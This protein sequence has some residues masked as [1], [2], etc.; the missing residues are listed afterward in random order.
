MDAVDLRDIDFDTV[1]ACSDA[2][3]L[4]RMIDLLVAEPYYPDLLAAARDR[5]R[6][7]S[8]VDAKRLDAA[9][10]P[11]PLSPTTPEIRSQINEWVD[12]IGKVDR[13][14][15][16]TEGGAAP[17]VR[18]GVRGAA[19]RRSTPAPVDDAMPGGSRQIQEFN[20]ER[21]KQI[22]NEYFRSGEYST[23]VKH[24]T[25]AI[26]LAPPGSKAAAVAYCN[27]AN[28][29]MRLK[30]WKAA[31]KDASAAIDCDPSY[32]KA[33]F[34]R[35]KARARL[36]KAVDARDDLAHAVRLDPDN[37]AI[38]DQLANV[39]KK[40]DG[41]RTDER[42]TRLSIVEED[43][44]G[45]DAAEGAPAPV[46]ETGDRDD[47]MDNARDLKR[48]GVAAFAKGDHERAVR[49]YTECITVCEGK[50][51]ER[52]DAA[53]LMAT[54]LSNRGLALANQGDTQG[55]E[56]DYS[57]ALV[58]TNGPC[59]LRS[60]LL[61]R[62]GQIREA[63]DDLEGAVSDYEQV[64]ATYPLAARNL[65][66]LRQHAA[67]ARRPCAPA[68][69]DESEAAVP[70]MPRVPQTLYDFQVAFMCLANVPGPR[71][72]AWLRMIPVD[73][74]CTFLATC[75]LEGSMLEQVLDVCAAHYVQEHP[76]QCLQLMR[77][78]ARSSRLAI[79]LMFSADKTRQDALN[80][81]AAIKKSCPDEDTSG[82]ESAFA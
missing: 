30:L 14:V 13:S 68:P 1:R 80:V 27:R 16:Q 35:G 63:L 21:E 55:A 31:E 34:I 20:A 15:R 8:P 33:W 4:R 57:R 40:V 59:D 11:E 25:R 46:V 6:E 44:E 37:K 72:Y 48:D 39:S 58:L 18:V 65:H 81:I 9:A 78:L 52:D 62:R 70:N 51:D 5:L 23:A 10:P 38:V 79:T 24:Y 26:A 61:M 12:D 42:F 45:E 41:E 22:G 69:A 53:L 54:T 50:L 36:G 2:R 74:L 66:R 28:T 82:I 56:R 29:S 75:T 60:K 17:I 7:I 19:D 77:A 32:V 71:L 76:R 67:G 43:D 47:D 64:A 73:A 3:R 49:L